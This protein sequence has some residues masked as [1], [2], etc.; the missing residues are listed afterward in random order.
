MWSLY[1]KDHGIA[2]VTTYERMRG[3]IRSDHQIRVGRIHYADYD[4]DFIPESNVISPF[5]HKRRSF[6]H[7][8]EVRALLS[9]FPNRTGPDGELMLDF[10]LPMPDGAIVDAALDKLLVE[11]RVAPTAP[12]WIANVVEDVTD[13]Y[14]LAVKV[15]HSDL[16]RDPVY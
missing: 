11:V 3:A 2:L 15:R 5:M 9:V 7:E 8:H 14:G 12:D 1:V 4:R 10:S 16:N 6:E 13:R